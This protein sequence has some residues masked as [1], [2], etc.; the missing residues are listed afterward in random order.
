L[1]GPNRYRD[2]IVQV[3]NTPELFNSLSH[4]GYGAPHYLQPAADFSQAHATAISRVELFNGGVYK[5]FLVRIAKVD[6]I[7]AQQNQAAS[8]PGGF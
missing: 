6:A 2:Y 1:K 8:Q 5:R 4:I 7:L 3:S